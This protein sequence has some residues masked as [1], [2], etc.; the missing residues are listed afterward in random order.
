MRKSF[1]CQILDYLYLANHKARKAIHI[2]SVNLNDI[3]VLAVYC[4][5]SPHLNPAIKHFGG[6]VIVKNK[7][8]S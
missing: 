1:S 2:V 5:S 7:C 8:G 4:V 3:R 6:F